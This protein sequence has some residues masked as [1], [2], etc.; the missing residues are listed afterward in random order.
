M[1]VILMTLR[2]LIRRSLCFHWRSH[3]GVVAGAALGS[4]ALIG[5][6]VVG[7]SV[8]GSLREQALG[9]LG[10]TDAALLPSDRLVTGSLAERMFRLAPLGSGAD[11]GPSLILPGTIDAIET[12]RRANSIQLIGVDG[13]FTRFG[14]DFW[15]RKWEPG[16]AC[17]NEALATHLGVEV[18]QTVIVRARKPAALSPDAPISPGSSESLSLRL[19]IAAL[20]PRDSLG[21]LNL[22]ASGPPALNL[23]L[24]LETLQ[25]EAG[26]AGRVNCILARTGRGHVSRPFAEM[27]AKMGLRDLWGGLG[28]SNGAMPTWSDS[29]S[30]DPDPAR[31]HAVRLRKVW[32]LADTQCTITPTTAGQLELRS[33]RVFLDS[34][35]ER[36]ALAA[37]SNA[38]PVLTY[39]ANLIRSASNATPYSMVTAAGPPWTP[40]NLAEDEI[41]LNQ[42][43]AD[44]LQARPGDRVTLVYYDPESGARLVE[45]THSFR[46]HGVVP[47]ELPWGIAR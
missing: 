34:P 29:T 8:K 1:R 41:V 6:L 5:A 25:Q 44:D 13:R 27:L 42:W 40:S 2:T 17:L 43:L 45:R 15:R 28:N 20:V 21:D 4:A 22:E 46:V 33:E 12:G 37:D 7:D 24:Q 38:R 23:F 18:G 9:R 16:T 47:M 3:L 36:A 39:I 11:Y 19:R 14:G 32:Q 10:E 35:I 30:R 31:T 26:G